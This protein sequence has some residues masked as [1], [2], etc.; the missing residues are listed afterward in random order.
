MGGHQDRPRER[1]LCCLSIWPRTV[2][3]WLFW[4]CY[5]EDGWLS[6]SRSPL[7]V[8]FMSIWSFFR[9]YS[10]RW[11][12]VGKLNALFYVLFYIW[13]VLNRNRKKI[14]NIYNNSPILWLLWCSATVV[15][16]MNRTL[17]HHSE[18]ITIHDRHIPTDSTILLEFGAS[19]CIDLHINVFRFIC[20]AKR[21]AIQCDFQSN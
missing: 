1:P 2:L 12:N 13:L 21:S 18:L 5:W 14:Y 16:I 19:A 8:C 17:S 11:T 9:F 20:R 6:R 7:W 10:Q 3:L 4:R 15:H